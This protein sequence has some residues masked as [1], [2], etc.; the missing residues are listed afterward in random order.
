MA[1]PRLI[2]PVPAA[3]EHALADAKALAKEQFAAA[4]RLQIEGL[5]EHLGTQWNAPL[6]HILEE[7]LTE[8]G[9][10]IHSQCEVKTRRE[11]AERLNL[12]SRRV[13]EFSTEQQWTQALADSTAGFCER[14]AV[15]LVNNARLELRAGRN[16]DSDTLGPVELAAA[17][18]FAGAVDTKDPVVALRTRGELSEPIAELF[19]ESPES[20][21]ALYPLVK[22]GR[23]AA[24]LY[25]DGTLEPGALELLASF[26][27]TVLDGLPDP[28]PQQL[29]T[30]KLQEGPAQWRAQR[31]AQVRV[32]EMRLYQSEA[33]KGG[34]ADH[35]LYSRLKR[36]IDAARELYRR[37]FQAHVGSMPDY[38]HLE[39]VRTLA[40]E[41]A[42]LLGSDYPGPLA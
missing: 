24:I 36:Q 12:A 28:Q 1:T 35:N 30:I 38:F 14:A 19:G 18:A 16:L 25:A 17:P 13:R 2:E 33:V 31:F 4:S 23:V 22:R 3:L 34:R 21:F 27:S 15:F 40:H 26:A 41:D 42:E 37:E 5:M 8:L 9:S 32:A 7:R 11:T 39:L 20:R 6:E 10:R 29:H